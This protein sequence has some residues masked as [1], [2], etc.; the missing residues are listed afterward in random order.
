[1]KRKQISFLLEFAY[2]MDALRCICLGKAGAD[3]LVDHT[4]HGF[5]ASFFAFIA[6]IP[7]MALTSVSQ[8]E[9]AHDPV[10][11]QIFARGDVAHESFSLFLWTRLLLALTNLI[12]FAALMFQIT[13]L[14]GRNKYHYFGFV[15]AWNWASIP[16][17]ALLLMPFLLFKI[18][19]EVPVLVF[20]MFFFWLLALWILWRVIRVM[21]LLEWPAGIGILLLYGTLTTLLDVLYSM[22][23]A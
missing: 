9:I 12:L 8:W 14:L 19:L 1:M 11:R 4:P 22:L 17:S 10:F 20:V 21:L 7:I 16:T 5:V 13:P 18:M 6:L 3:N 2:Y 15:T 23:L